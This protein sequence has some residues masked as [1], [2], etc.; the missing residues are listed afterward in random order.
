MLKK[1]NVTVSTSTT[2]MSTTQEAMKGDIALV[3][4]RAGGTASEPTEKCKGEATTTKVT[5]QGRS[6]AK[7][8]IRGFAEGNPT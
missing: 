3:G 4:Q 5:T 2:V 6:V 1:S 8:D 7:N